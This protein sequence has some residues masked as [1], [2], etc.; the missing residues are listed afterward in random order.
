LWIDASRTCLFTVLL[1]FTS[2][3]YKVADLLELVGVGGLHGKSVHGELGRGAAEESL[4]EVAQELALRVFLGGGGAVDVGF[5]GLGAL[6]Q[7]LL[8]HDLQRLEDGGVAERA[9]AA[10][11]VV[12]LADG[13]FAAGPEGGKDLEFHLCWLGGGLADELREGT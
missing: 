1:L 2:F 13:G 9:L 7:A 6:D 8:G 11:V 10:N 4:A 5:A 12:E 3:F